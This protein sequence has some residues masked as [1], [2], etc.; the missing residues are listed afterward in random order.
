[1]RFLSAAFVLS[2][3]LTFLSGCG[4]S[5]S[6]S[7]VE[8]GVVEEEVV[9]EE[10]VVSYT[11]NPDEVSPA[12]GVICENNN[13]DDRTVYESADSPYASVKCKWSCATYVKTYANGEQLIRRNKYV[14]LRFYKDY[15]SGYKWYLSSDYVSDGIGC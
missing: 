10:V 4:Q 2:V 7:G 12:K 13:E 9:E 6:N 15:T 14:I 3:A 8:E 1:M 5:G 11:V